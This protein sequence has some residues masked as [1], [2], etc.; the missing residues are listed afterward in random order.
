MRVMIASKRSQI[1]ITMN[2][3]TDTYDVPWE[4]AFSAG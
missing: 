2:L 4:T 1:C 3:L